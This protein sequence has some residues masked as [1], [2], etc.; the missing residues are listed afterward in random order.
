[1][2]NI[3]GAAGCRAPETFDERRA[4]RAGRRSR[5]VH[6]DVAQQMAAPRGNVERRT[7]AASTSR[8]GRHDVDVGEYATLLRQRWTTVRM[9]NM[10]ATAPLTPRPQG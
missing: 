4:G 7:G 8:H 10:G 3:Y 6:V 9:S 1:M 5:D 2:R